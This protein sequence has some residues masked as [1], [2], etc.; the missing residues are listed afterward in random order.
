MRI[1]IDA[2]MMGK[3]QATGIGVYIEQIVTR[4]I[5]KDTKNHYVIFVKPENKHLLDAYTHLSHV[6]IR[7]TPC[8]WYSLCEQ[9]I[10]CV[11]LYK[12]RLDL[13]HV[14]QFNVPLLYNKPFI[15]T[16][17]DITPLR[18]P[19]H[20]MTSRIRRWAFN[21]VFYHA[22]TK[23]RAI[24]TVSEYTK[25]Q[26]QA[27]FPSLTTP[28]E[29]TYLGVENNFVREENYDKIQEVQKSFSLTKPYFLYLGVLRNHKNIHGLV[30]AFALVREKHEYALVLGGVQAP[31]YHEL[32]TA[33]NELSESTRADIILPGFI[34]DAD[35]VLLYQGA[36]AYVVPSFEEGFGINGLEAMA[37]GVPVIASQAG[38]LPEIYADAAYYCDP[39]DSANIADAMT[40]I[41]TS[42]DIRSSLI[43][44]GYERLSH[45]S[46]DI[47]ADKTLR[48]YLDTK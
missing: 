7:L 27:L 42:P 25:S 36:L 22:L 45:Y 14:P 1:G 47:T 23:A 19:G 30:R 46:W 2:R 8:H 33:L 48:C 43:Q 38:S 29:V 15:V 21:K 35:V 44:K 39:Y 4:I 6:E 10:F 13:L 16:I 32:T 26:I 12:A 41:I 11:Q 20:K 24:I 34:P 28:C 40:T 31:N 9:F 18:F 37:L 5:T 3:Q 17:H